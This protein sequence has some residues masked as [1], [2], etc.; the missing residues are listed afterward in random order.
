MPVLDFRFPVFG[1]QIPVDHGYL[2]YSALSAVLPQIDLQESLRDCKLVNLGI[3]TEHSAAISRRLVSV[4]HHRDLRDLL[5][6]ATG[7]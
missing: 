7:L 2:L 1:S 5:A 6:G 3:N 4:G